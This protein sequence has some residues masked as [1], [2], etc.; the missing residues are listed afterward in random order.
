MENDRLRRELKQM[1]KNLKEKEKVE[2]DLNSLRE[3]VLV[4][5]KAVLPQVYIRSAENVDSVLKKFV[6]D[7]EKS[8]TQTE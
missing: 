8:N 6:K 3:N 7:Q 1:K 5:L 4:L 2:K